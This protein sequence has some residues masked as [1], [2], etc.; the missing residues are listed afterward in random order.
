MKEL[1][2]W[3]RISDVSFSNSLVDLD[4]IKRLMR[5]NR[6]T[7]MFALNALE[8]YRRFAYLAIVC[9]HEVTP[10]DEVDQVWHLHLQYTQHYWGVWTIAL[11]KDLHHGP[12]LG[13]Q[14][15]ARRFNDNYALTLESYK[16]EFSSNPPEHIWPNSKIRFTR[17]HGFARIN[18]TEF[19]LLRTRHVILFLQALGCCIISIFS[20][21]WVLAQENE[22]DNSGFSLF[23]ILAFGLFF[24][25]VLLLIVKWRKTRKQKNEES[26]AGSAGCAFYTP[27]NS[28]SD[29]GNEGGSGCS[30]CGG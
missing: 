13:G 25:F 28:T 19:L 21:Q 5:E 3:N 29:S 9:D 30:G 10:S 6:W 27:P 7:R 16:R 12:T 18:T 22:S 2:L 4:F 14:K 24:F 11:G 20:I 15:E 17:P 23:E 8:E 1:E 26:A